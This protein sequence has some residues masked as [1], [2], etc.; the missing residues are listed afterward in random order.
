MLKL[1]TI[2]FLIGALVLAVLHGIAETLSLYW[3]YWW[4]DLP[5]HLFGGAIVALGWFTLHDLGLWVRTEHLRLLSIWLLSLVVMLLW[6]VF[7]LY[8]GKE[9]DEDFVLDTVLDLTMGSLGSLIGF[10]VAKQ[11][12]TL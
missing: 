2:F 1:T 5:M 3:Y 6:E 7:K 9:I 8:A 4:F 12:R 10:Y 11:L